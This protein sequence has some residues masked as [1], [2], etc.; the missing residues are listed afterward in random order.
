MPR[1]ST[2]K[3]L[4]HHMKKQVD[5]MLEKEHLSIDNIVEW[6]ETEHGYKISRSAMGRYSKE[7]GDLRS[8][9]R[10]SREVAEAFAKELGPDAVTGKQGALLIEILQTVLFKNLSSQL[11]AG[12]LSDDDEDLDSG[13]FMKLARAIK[14]LSQANRFNQDFAE[15]LRVQI[16]EEER[17]RAAAA[18]KEG[19]RKAG[20]S[21]EARA[22][23]EA[24]L[25]IR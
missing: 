3:G 11:Q 16:R 17:E 9:L 23:I 25:G 6:L 5:F 21:D 12:P 7:Y 1:K 20:L 15:K 14:D 2:V 8:S 10:E 19:G 24:E 4:P 22:I 18:V 13:D